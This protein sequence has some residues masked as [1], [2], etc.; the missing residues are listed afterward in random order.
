MKQAFHNLLRKRIIKTLQRATKGELSLSFNSGDPYNF[1]GQATGPRAS[2]HIHDARCLTDMALQ[3]DIGLGES[4]EAGQ[5]DSPDLTAL[6]EWFLI[7]QKALEGD[8]HPWLQKCLQSLLLGAERLRHFTHRNTRDQSRKNISAHYDLGNEFYGSFLDESMTYSSA[9]FSH[10]GQNLAEAQV[11]KYDR[12]CRKLDLQSHHRIL[13]IGTGWGGFSLHAARNYGCHITTTTI[14][15]EQHKLARQRIAEAGLGDQVEVLLTDYRD[16]EGQYD[17]IVSIEMLEA[18]GHDFLGTYFSQCNRLLKPDGL[19]AYQV[20]LC[21][22]HLYEGY[23]KRVD[24]IRKNIFPG[25][26]LPS[27]KAIQD[28]LV[29]SSVPWDLC[30]FE[31]F[32]LHY[33]ETLRHW[34]K[35]FNQSTDQQSHPDLDPAFIRRWNCYLSYC[36]AGFRQRHVHVAQL[37]FA[38]P[39][40]T[41]Y[42]YELISDSRSGHKSAKQSIELAS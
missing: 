35:R 6:F 20:I 36:E 31:N 29:K 25:G 17:R 41:A 14:S 23:R 13:E 27:L 3:G 32:G 42:R 15:A 26:H 34:Q 28:S 40:T 9:F 38:H 1:G 33:A 4:Y 30:H 19:A 2:M 22:D 37:V 5:W 39:D 16:L 11:E 12:I 8:T 21:P 18:V 7:N 24:Y 10:P